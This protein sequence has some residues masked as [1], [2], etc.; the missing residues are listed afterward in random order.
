M[1]M[2]RYHTASANARNWSADYGLS[3]NAESIA[4]LRAY[5][6]Y[7]NCA[8]EP[9]IRRRSSRPPSQDD[10]VVPWHSYKFGAALQ[11]AQGCANPILVS[12]ETR[13]GHRDG[14]PVWMWVEDYADQWAFL[15]SN[16]TCGST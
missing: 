9:A 1:D 4:R 7:H 16:S 10:R 15:A 14:R 3:E 13:A 11:H 8:T 6:P 2:L 5:S 12:V